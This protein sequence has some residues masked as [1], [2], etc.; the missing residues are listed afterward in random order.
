MKTILLVATIVLSGCGSCQRT[1]TGITGGLTEK[2]FR[3][4]LYLQSDSGLTAALDIDG[5][6]LACK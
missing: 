1:Y 6:P 5:N 2:C 3:G 4:V